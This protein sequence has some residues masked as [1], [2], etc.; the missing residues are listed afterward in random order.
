MFKHRHKPLLLVI[1]AFLAATV[2]TAAAADAFEDIISLEELAFRAALE[3]VA[4][5]VVRIETVGGAERIDGVSFGAGPT[6]GLVVD[7]N[8]YIISS[9]FNFLHQPDSILVQLPDGARKPAQLLATDHNRKLVLLKIDIDRPLPTP[10]MAASETVRVGQWAI[11]VGRTFN[12]KGPNASVGIVSA[13]NRVWGRA[14]QTDAAVSPANYGGPLV[15]IHGRVLGVLA[16]L[17]PE[18]GDAAGAVAWYDSGIGFAVPTNE[19]LRVLP[20]LRQGEDIHTGRLG[21]GLAPGDA[22]TAEPIVA[23]CHPGSPAAKA[24][25]E[26]GD[27][28]VAI[29]GR[30]MSR[31]AEVKQALGPRDAGETIAVTIQRNGKRHEHKITLVAELPQ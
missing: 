4:A 26:P 6:A 20:R 15:D 23:T 21:I 18:P 2:A 17:S 25:L 31:A 9:V 5:S 14:I 13:L 1:A 3:R 19:I 12:G 28:I 24:G 29:D 27:R 16:P 8:G 11:A 7:A 22:S 10:E 30:V